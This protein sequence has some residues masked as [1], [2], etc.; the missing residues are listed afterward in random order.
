MPVLKQIGQ[1][2]LKKKPLKGL[3]V[4]ACMHITKETGAL[5]TTLMAGGARVYLAASNP[6]STQPGVV[7]DL[8]KYGVTVFHRDYDT[9]I[10]RLAG[11]R[12]HLIMD[13]GG[14]LTWDLTNA[15]DSWRKNLIGGMEETTTGVVRLR[16]LARGDMLKFPM[17]AVNDTPTKR[18]FDNVYGTGQSTMEAIVMAT[19]VLMAGKC[20]VVAGYGHCGAGVTARA[21]GMGARVI[22]TEVDPRKALQAHMNG[23][24]VMTMRR[25]ALEGD[26]FV[27]VTGDINVITQEHMMLMKDGAVVANAGHFDVEIDIKNVPAHVTLL[28]EGR[29]VNLAAGRGHPP[30]VMDMSFSNQALCA[31]WL[32]NQDDTFPFRHPRIYDVP[33]DI[34]EYVARE[35]LKALNICIDTLTDEQRQYL[36]NFK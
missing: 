16:A 5:M 10:K 4:A 21:K 6:L 25:A 24:E 17:I 3:V 13:D 15:P 2:F 19:N 11:T 9:D 29:L 26:V 7:K 30:A 22:V 36:N 8:A 27:T 31:E 14:D 34:D 35:K 20:V 18:L 12:P 23:Y 1:R 33:E 28:A 32:A